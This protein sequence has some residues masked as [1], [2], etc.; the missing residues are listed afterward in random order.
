MKPAAVSAADGSL[1]P[2]SESA[3][4]K[5]AND[6]DGATNV[7]DGAT[8]SIWTVADETAER[9]P[10]SVARTRIVRVA[11]PSI[12]AAENVTLWPGVSNEPLLSRSHA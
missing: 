5:P 4:G 7:A 11:G 3:N 9:P 8:F 2:V 12:V 1:G 10:A 6:G